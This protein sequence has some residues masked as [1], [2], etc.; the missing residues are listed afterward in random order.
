MAKLYHHKSGENRLVYLDLGKAFSLSPKERAESFLN[1]NESA[2]D[3]NAK[4]VDAAAKEFNDKLISDSV[5]NLKTSAVDIKDKTISIL[6]DAAKAPLKLAA[7]AVTKPIEWV[8]K[9]TVS[10]VSGTL[11]AASAITTNVVG[12]AATAPRIALD[13][14]R[15]V[16]RVP[17]I[18]LDKLSVLSGYPSSL[19]RYIKEK[20]LGLIDKT[21]EKIFE[22]SADTRNKIFATIGAEA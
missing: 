20:I 18:I 13:A 6:K 10:L 3:H 7:H 15:L 8:G 5:E 19:V 17:L 9:P 14:A 11:K 4:M 21:N 2:S 12:V 1:D 22:I 16:P